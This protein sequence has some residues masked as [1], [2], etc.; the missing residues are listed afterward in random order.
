[1]SFTRG[2]LIVRMA[3]ASLAMFAMTSC[4][5]STIRSLD[6]KA[7][8]HLR[9]SL[10]SVGFIATPRRA[11]PVKLSTGYFQEIPRDFSVRLLAI[12][13]WATPPTVFRCRAAKSSGRGQ[14]GNL[15]ES[16]G[17]S[18]WARRYSSTNFTLTVQAALARSPSDTCGCSVCAALIIRGVVSCHQRK[19]PW[20]Y[21]KGNVCY[22]SVTNVLALI[23]SFFSPC[24]STVLG[25]WDN[26]RNLKV[27][28]G[29]KEIWR[30]NPSRG[31]A[32]HTRQ[33][34]EE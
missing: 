24:R 21:S 25:T 17:K 7:P 18:P 14:K 1:M 20:K 9:K 22:C 26:L 33:Y 11:K 16:H 31:R 23:P 28:F 6:L 19:Q 27:Q 30:K 13:L 29:S 32:H 34:K 3:Q 2:L 4:V 8:T 12:V 10:E 5:Q 15:K